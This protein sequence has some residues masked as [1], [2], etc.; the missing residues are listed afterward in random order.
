MVQHL[1]IGA[2]IYPR[3]D[4]IDFTGPFEVLSRI[5][6]STIHV[7]WKEKTPVRDFN[8]LLLVPE[9]TLA[10]VPRLDLLVVPGGPGQ[11]ALME[12]EPVLSF[13][14]AQ[15]A[16]AQC[17]FSICTGA[18]LLGAAGLLKNTK[19]TTHW[20]SFQLLE[21]FGAIPVKQRVV[22]DG[23]LVTAAGVTAG[24]D[25]ALLVAAMLRGDQV[26]KEIQ[27]AIEYAPE[28][29]FDCGTPITAPP[30][31]RKAVEN[32]FSGLIAHRLATAKRVAARLGIRTSAGAEK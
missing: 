19:A 27:L 15:A 6:D 23:K 24:I 17:V 4:Q 5:P 25:G 28:P 14:R 18:L 31:V 9:M 8:G 1:N 7:A 29:P 13:I 30:E 2:I 16:Q 21:Y 10:E 22:V 20:P 3:M 11:E 12:D 26:A 32:Q